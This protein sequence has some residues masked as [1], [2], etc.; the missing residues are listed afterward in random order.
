ML[1]SVRLGFARLFFCNGDLGQNYHFLS[2]LVSIKKSF[3]GFKCRFNKISIIGSWY[4]GVNLKMSSDSTILQ[5]VSLTQLSDLTLNGIFFILFQ[6]GVFAFLRLLSYLMFLP[7]TLGRQCSVWL[8]LQP[9]VIRGWSS[10]FLLVQFGFKKGLLCGAHSSQGT[11][12]CFL[13]LLEP[14]Q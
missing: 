14:P 11:G 13:P 12:P 3:W 1:D 7:V 5:G 6:T 8:D 10:W 2:H 4:S 9:V